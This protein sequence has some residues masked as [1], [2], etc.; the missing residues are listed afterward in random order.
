MRYMAQ[1]CMSRGIY[2]S[3]GRKTR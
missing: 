3:W 2:L 1:Y